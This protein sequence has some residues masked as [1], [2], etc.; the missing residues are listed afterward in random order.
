MNGFVAGF[1]RIFAMSAEVMRGSLELSFGLL[2]FTNCA[3][4]VRMA[5]AALGPFVV[6]RCR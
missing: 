2:K 4:N 5:L 6:L 1:Y 3:A